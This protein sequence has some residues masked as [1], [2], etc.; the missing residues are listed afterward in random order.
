V[1]QVQARLDF[2]T[3]AFS[4]EKRTTFRYDA[5]GSVQVTEVGR[6]FVDA[7]SRT[8]KIVNRQALRLSLV[9]GQ[10]FDVL[11]DDFAEESIDHQLENAEHLAELASDAAGVT[12]ALRILEAVAADGREWIILERQRLY[13]RRP[14][15]RA[16]APTAYPPLPT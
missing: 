10:T 3:G 4:G 12:S 8:Q 15:Q 2:A 9:N 13:R 1:R 6:R 16:A 5:I 7:R 11:L 14:R